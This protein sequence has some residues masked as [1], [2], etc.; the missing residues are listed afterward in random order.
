MKTIQLSLPD[1]IFIS[2]RE[3]PDELSKE[4]LI[5]AAAK[6]YELSKLSSG[7]ASKLAGIPRVS[8]LQLLAQYNVPIFDLTMDELEQD[9]H[10]A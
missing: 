9:L 10:N 5:V 1:E 7:R 8:F 6:L 4:I 2:M 3:T